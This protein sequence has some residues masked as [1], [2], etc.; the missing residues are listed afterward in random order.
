M[1]VLKKASGPSQVPD[2]PLDAILDVAVPVVV[3]NS[4]ILNNFFA[5]VPGWW[6]ESQSET[7]NLDPVVELDNNSGKLSKLFLEANS[8]S[9]PLPIL[10]CL[11]SS[12]KLMSCFGMM[13]SQLKNKTFA[14]NEPKVYG[15]ELSISVFHH[16]LGALGVDA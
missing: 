2:H 14:S 9:S 16:V 12:M 6:V 1:I 5:T 3:V 11:G 13:S 10:V 15:Y 7:S 4:M 8:F